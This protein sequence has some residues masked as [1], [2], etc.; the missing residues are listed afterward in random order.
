VFERFTSQARAAVVHAQEE[1]R[2]LRHS[3]IGTEHVLVGL[4]IDPV[5]AGG[6]AL[7]ALGL[8]LADARA[9]LADL[10]P[11][12]HRSFAPED[13]EALRTLG[14]DLDEVRRSVE[15]GFGPGALERRWSA[16]RH[17]PFDAEA[18]KVLELSLREALRLGDKHIGTE[19]IALA[20]LREG[21]RSGAARLLDARGIALDRLRSEVEAEIRRG[22]DRPERTA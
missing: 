8:D 3:R 14:I 22:G 2:R 10:F 5:G 11:V 1:A 9:D 16:G 17:I 20:L 18:K 19:H 4:L 15:D 7:R 12:D 13:A 6:R 21:G